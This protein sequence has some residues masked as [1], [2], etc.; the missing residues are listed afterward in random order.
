MTSE[1]RQ[2]STVGEIVNLMSIDAQNI[3][4]F[5]S[6]F[7]VLWSSPLQSCFSLYFLY[8]TMGHSMWSGIG[9][10]LILI[11]LNGFVISKIHKH[12]AQQMRQKDERIKLLSEVLNGI[13]VY[14]Y[15]FVKSFQ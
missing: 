9:V 12:Q 1:A 6:Y 13:K 14:M 3:Q 2:N 8:D 7:W 11:P 5:I 15:F 4:D 10:L